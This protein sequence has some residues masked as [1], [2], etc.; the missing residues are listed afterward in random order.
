MPRSRNHVPLS[1]PPRR[2]NR[3]AALIFSLLALPLAAAWQPL[4]KVRN[5]IIMIPGGTSHSLVTLTRLYAVSPLTLDSIQSGSTRTYTPENATI[6]TAA[7]TAAAALAT[8]R[9]KDNTTPT[10]FSYRKTTPHTTP[11][12]PVTILQAARD[13]RQAAVGI[14]TASPPTAPSIAPFSLTDISALDLHITETQITQHNLNLFICAS[15]NTSFFTP[16]ANTPPTPHAD[17]THTNPEQPTLAVL[18][19]KALAQ[20]RQHPTGFI[21]VVETPLIAACCRN[22]DTFGAVSELYA[23]DQ[24]VR[25]AL[26]FAITDRQTLLVVTPGYEVGGLT[27]PATPLI[28][29]LI[30][31]DPWTPQLR[32][33][34]L[35]AA[36]LEHKLAGDYT[37]ANIAAHMRAWWNVRPSAATLTAIETMITNGQAPAFAMAHALSTQHLN[38]SWSTTSC[39]AGDIPLWSFGPQRLYGTPDNAEIGV[40]IAAALS[41]T[42]TN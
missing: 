24:A 15:T 22:H 10:T 31:H 32:Q 26:Q 4:P 40:A 12:P 6:N 23:F 28:S 19:A 33:M 37:T 29:P 39:T 2:Y 41:L 9:Y 13:Q 1:P 14:V 8:G 34:R 21:L 16:Y 7:A 18:T 11:A 42:L 25:V 20:L 3:C 38:L 5:A 17:I 36:A 35:S 30:S 27:L